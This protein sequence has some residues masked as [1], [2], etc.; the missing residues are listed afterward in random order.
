MSGHSKWSTIKRQK[1]INDAKKGAIFTKLA[2]AITIAVKEGG[3]DPAMNMKLR[4]AIEKARQ[5]NMPK[6]NIERAVRAAQGKLDNLVELTY[7]GYAP[8]GVPVIVEAATDNKNRTAQEIKNI[9][10]RGGGSFA[11]PGSVAF[12]FERSGQLVVEKGADVQSQ[13]LELIDLGVEDMEEVEDGIEVYTKPEDLFKTKQKVE[14]AGINVQTAELVYRPRNNVLVV[15]SG[16]A[17]KIVRL[18]E[19]LDDHDDVQKVY[20][21]VDIQSDAL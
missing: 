11:S 6:D 20:A 8:E 7:E 9:F 4:F 13:M 10:E 19:T 17:G 16:K 21:G 18:L 12:N 2:K 14:V 15:D 1:G 3:A 5:S